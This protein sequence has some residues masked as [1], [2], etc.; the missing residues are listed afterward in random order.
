MPGQPTCEFSLEDE[1]GKFLTVPAAEP[2]A[3]E[4][5]TPSEPGG[6]E[7]GEEELREEIEALKGENQ[8]LP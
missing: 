3:P 2:A 1:G 7:G 4:D 8:T 6:G 5:P